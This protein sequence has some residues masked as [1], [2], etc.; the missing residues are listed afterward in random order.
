M[1]R[2]LVFLSCLVLA[3]SVSGQNASLSLLN[4]LRKYRLSFSYEYEING[5][6]DV[7]VQGSAI[8]QN[9][10]FRMEGAGLLILCNAE[11]I[12]T[13]DIQG[14]EAYVETAGD[15][16]YADYLMDL[17][18]EDDALVGSI[19]EPSTG[20]IINFKLFNIIKNSASGDLSIF[21]PSTDFF[22]DGA[23]WI[24]TDLR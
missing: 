16:D 14:K 15:M 12:W 19:N 7:I 22:N 8:I 21:S 23:D 3:I 18:W 13:I 11:D 2:I 24:I 17:H 6:Q 5:L 4:D 10:C 1:K 9:D 20:A